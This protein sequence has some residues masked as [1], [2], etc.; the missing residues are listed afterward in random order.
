MK[1]TYQKLLSPLNVRGFSLKNRM[2]SSNSLPHFLQGPEEFP[3][4]GVIRHYSNRAK[5]GAAVVSVGGVNNA[6]HGK[7]YKMDM[8]MAHFVDW[9]LYD[10]QCQ[11]YL[12]HLAD[13]IHY[14]Q[15]VACM[16]LFVGPP[17]YYPLKKLLAP[18]AEQGE[19]NGDTGDVTRPFDVPGEDRFE[20]EQVPAHLLPHEYDLETLE[21][22]ADSY[23]EQ[24]EILRALDYEMINI[25]MCY[26]G[27]LPAKFF[28]PLTN[29][30][31]DEFGGS[32]ENRM[33]FPLMVLQRMRERVGKNTILEIEW[34][35]EE[36][37]GGYTREESVAF[38]QAA[39]EYVDIVELRG[40]EADVSHPTGFNLNPHPFLEDAAYMKEHV[41]GLL[42]AS[43][44]GYQDPAAMEQAL[45]EGKTDLFAMARSWISNHDYGELVSKGKS[46]DI[47]PCLRCNKCHGRGPNDPL[48][49]VCS[50]NPRIGIEH[51]LE[52]LISPVERKKRVA[53][54]GGG[55]A[56]L[57]C[58]LF[59]AE[60]G[61]EVTIYEADSTLGG[62][63]RHSDYAS[64]K[65]PL[66]NFK[67]YLIAQ[68]E[69]KDN[70]TVLLS[71]KATP[72]LVAEAEYDAVVAAVGATPICPPIKGLSS[73][74]VYDAAEGFARADELGKR[75]AVI[76]GGEVGVE[77]GMHL[78]QNGHDVTVL[79]MRDML[80]ADS[81]KIH[82]RSM[83][84]DAWE[85]TP[86]FKGIVNAR[87]SAVEQGVVYYQDAEG[88]FYSVLADSIIV[89]AGMCAKYE[90]ATA[91]YGCAE[92]FYMIGD[93]TKAATIQQ[94][95][96]SAFA[97]ANKI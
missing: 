18:P 68:V 93:C 95:M 97:V 74:S 45:R 79:E 29:K 59:L 63:I 65:W 86:N 5:S 21:K 94:A 37:P 77:V 47:V 81:T 73:V 61:H 64:F 31:E 52:E 56:G 26:R 44:G 23:A 13:V 90:E 34:S 9:N 33:R 67:N 87:V 92:E 4:D 49:T 22:I 69:K 41:P 35:T 66:R 58:A 20:I 19:Y 78:A 71:T 12:I 50:V 6:I 17:S 72:E 30:R 42:I 46:E 70:I 48:V 7:Q 28:S 2:I 57:R 39:K 3:A 51:R 40:C 96:R 43:I 88:V 36:I 24:A 16:C 80:A 55:P 1:P 15:S 89:S 85:A 38:L 14:H 76:G 53:I 54:I 82:Y 91:F 25:H 62:A 75:V 10:C 60:R 27:N 8:D 83:F 32:L 84:R 11:N